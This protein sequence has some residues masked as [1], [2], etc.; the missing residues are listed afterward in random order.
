MDGVHN[1][2]RP[3]PLHLDFR[4]PSTFARLR[5]SLTLGIGI[6]AITGAGFDY[7]AASDDLAAV[8]HRKENLE[9]KNARQPN[10]SQEG[11]N[12]E[13]PQMADAA[14]QL[15]RPWDLLLQELED[16]V[17]NSVALLS[18]EPDPG[19]QQLRISGEARELTDVLAFVKRLEQA[20][21]LQQP[22]L[23]SHQT[24]QSNAGTIVVFTVQAA[25][26]SP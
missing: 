2:N 4:P 19:R 26:R 16:K 1:M 7:L 22:T 6:L 8:Q 23:T 10:R 21:S 14:R 3:R 9:R 17:D 5:N 13:S 20:T 11:S 15:Q 24:R 25:W 12:G 18:V